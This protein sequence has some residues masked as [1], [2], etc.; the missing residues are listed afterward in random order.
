MDN[1][2]EFLSER[3]LE[4]NLTGCKHNH[5]LPL[6]SCYEKIFNEKKENMKFIFGAGAQFIVAKKILQKP[7]NFYLKIITMLEKS[8]TQ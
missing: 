6:I 8:K 1:D 7:K 4:C 3:I 5:R 2:F